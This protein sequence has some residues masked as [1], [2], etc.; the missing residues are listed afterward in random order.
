MELEIG[1][2]FLSKVVVRARG[3]YASPETERRPG[4]MG[5]AWLCFPSMTFCLMTRVHL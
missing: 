3:V 2:L 1:A 5:H 4:E